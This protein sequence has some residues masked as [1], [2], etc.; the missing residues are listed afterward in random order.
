MPIRTSPASVN[1]QIPVQPQAASDVQQTAAASS[2]RRAG[3][4][5]GQKAGQSGATT[6]SAFDGVTGQ[7]SAG[8]V[9]GGGGGAAGLMGGALG[10]RLMGL[11]AKT[12]MQPAQLKA[13]L[14]TPGGRAMLAGQLNM[15][16]KTDPSVQADAAKAEKAVLGMVAQANASGALPELLG[17]LATMKGSPLAEMPAPKRE[18]LVAQLAGMIDAELGARGM[19]PD[20]VGTTYQTWDDLAAE[21]LAAVRNTDIAPGGPGEPS[22]LR[23]PAFIK[24]LEAL[25]GASFTDNNVTEPLIDGPASFAAREK[26]IEGATDSIH[27]MSWAFYDDV[28]GMDTADKLIAKHNEGVDVRI[29]VDGQVAA[30]PHHHHALDKMEAAGIDVV[31]WRDAERPYDGQHRKLMVVDGETAIAGGMNVGD[32]YSHMGEVDGQKWRDT[33]VKMQGGAV[34]DAEALFAGLWN[35]QAEA[36][37]DV[38]KIGDDVL[39]KA[40]DFAQT[41]QGEGKAAV[42]DHVPGPDG[43]AHIL[44]ATLKAIEGA[45]EKVD[46]ENA[47]FISTPDIKDALLSALERGVQVRILTNSA[48]SV[49]EPIVTAPILG[50]LPELADAGA[51]IYLKK[52]DTLHSKFMVVDDAFVSV[53]SYNLH[54][55]SQRYEGELMMNV[56]DDDFASSMHSTFEADIA[57]AHHAK[58]GADIEVPS[59][60]MSKLASRYFFDQL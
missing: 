33:D 49:D 3:D 55:R 47:Y 60:A 50:S 52:G 18:A 34:A 12:G 48:D 51:E 26:L 42:V 56:L 27:M 28:T 13:A 32:M 36:G 41:V 14:G 4:V 15:L 19:T 29:I 11:S 57:A 44:Q 22:R 53:G 5:A 17:Q 46:I 31:R 38:G 40:A 54:P 30:R 24:E 43:D 45:T 37:A 35:A 58:T 23:N 7:A 59:S 8:D 1:T 20:T 16:L 39:Q 25:Q 2:A 6:A 21:N 9:L 10:A